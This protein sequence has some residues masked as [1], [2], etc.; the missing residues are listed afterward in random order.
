MSFK[1]VAPAFVSAAL[2][3]GITSAVLA[4]TWFEGE[5]KSAYSSAAEF[6]GVTN[7]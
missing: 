6:I 5:I 2:V 1:E 7:P 3:I 4:A